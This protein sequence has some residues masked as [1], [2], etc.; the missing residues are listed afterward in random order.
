MLNRTRETLTRPTMAMVYAILGVLGFFPFAIPVL[1]AEE[2]GGE[3]LRHPQE[4]HLAEIRQMTFGGE[5]AEA[6]WSPDGRELS[7]QSTRPPYEC[8]QIFRMS[9]GEPET[10]ALVSTGVGR[11]TCAHFT[12][13]GERVVFSSTHLD[14][15]SCPP[16]PDFSQGYVWP[17]YD[18]FDIFS[19]LADGS[20]LVRLTETEAYDAE[21]TICSVDGSILFTSTRDSDLELYRMDADGGNVRRLTHTP[22]YDGGAFFSQDCSKIVWRASRPQAGDELTDYRRLL[23]QNM[24]RPSKLEIFVADADGTDVRQVTELGAASFAPF[25]YPS[26]DR[27]IFS[28]N[29][30]DSSGREFDIW[31]VNVD[32]TGLERITYSPGFDGF[33]V[34]S[35]DGRSLAFSSNRNQ[36]KPGETNVFVASWRNEGS[37]SSN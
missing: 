30:G 28:S 23:D 16:V 33:P 12:A 34:F 25:F 36:G 3:S 10:P 5:N 31:A 32:G 18:S 35:P 4:I 2:A 19:A 8:D 1:V 24:V 6:Y 15:E 17:L 20:G 13:G 26:G 22:G 7:F 21:A 11:T 9:V 14:S 37:D 29:H 27:V